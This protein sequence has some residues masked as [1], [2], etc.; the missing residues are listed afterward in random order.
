MYKYAVL[1][2]LTKLAEEKSKDNKSN[3]SKDTSKKDNKNDYDFLSVGPYEV[4]PIELS[5]EQNSAMYALRSAMERGSG[6]QLRL[7][8]YKVNDV[9]SATDMKN[10]VR[11]NPNNTAT[12]MHEYGHVV[13]Q[14]NMLMLNILNGIHPAFGGMYQ[15]RQEVDANKKGLDAFRKGTAHNKALGDEINNVYSMTRDKALDTYKIKNRY[16]SAGG[17]LGSILGGGVGYISS[18]E[19]KAMQVMRALGGAWVGGQ[20]GGVAGDMLSSSKVN[21]KYNEVINT[22]NSNEYKNAIN[23]FNRN[24]VADAQANNWYQPVA[25][26]NS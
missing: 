16:R 21:K 3:N 12:A 7:Q 13:D 2:S 5:P 25:V 10:W 11:Y 8:P 24:L 17:I 20:L 4:E 18:P 15:V 19:D 22:L 26:V 1:Y 23:N 6:K 9:L 14:P